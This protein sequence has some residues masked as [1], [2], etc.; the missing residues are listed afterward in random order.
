LAP[1]SS[2]RLR[3]NADTDNKQRAEAIGVRRD[4]GFVI[5]EL[6]LPRGLPEAAI[7]TKRAMSEQKTGVPAGHDESDAPRRRRES[8]LNLTEVWNS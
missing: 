3:L 7:R 1:R 4:K 5:D 6:H 2:L 8:G